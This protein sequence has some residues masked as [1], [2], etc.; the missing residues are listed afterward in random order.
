M[1]ERRQIV[2]QNVTEKST[3]SAIMNLCRM[4]LCHTYKGELWQEN[5]LRTLVRLVFCKSDAIDA[6]P[7]DALL[8]IHYHHILYCGVGKIPYLYIFS[9]S[10]QHFNFLLMISEHY[11]FL[12]SNGFSVYQPLSR[13]RLYVNLGCLYIYHSFRIYFI[14]R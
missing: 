7:T 1:K 4:H 10:D 14:C 13:I 3:E 8:S 5:N 12:N 9:L 2:K 6:H 11:F